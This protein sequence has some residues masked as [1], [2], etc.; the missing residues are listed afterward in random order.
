M[1]TPQR[2]VEIYAR[3]LFN[4]A[5][6]PVG[7]FLVC[8]SLKPSLINIVDVF[9]NEFQKKKLITGTNKSFLNYLSKSSMTYLKLKK[10]LKVKTFPIIACTT[11]ELT[12]QFP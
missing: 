10:R 6:F 2:N 12:F 7:M 5:V 1:L 4:K 8:V 11:C 3:K 9:K